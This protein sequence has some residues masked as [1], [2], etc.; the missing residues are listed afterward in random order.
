MVLSMTQPFKHPKTGI[1][2]YRKV[3]PEPL[4]A[5][6][7]KREEK[8]SLKTKDPQIAKQRHIE[9][10][11][12]I[13]RHWAALSEPATN[14]SNKQIVA[15]SGILYRDATE[16]FAE[17]PGSPETWEHLKRVDK[18]AREKGK[19][20]QWYGQTVDELLAKEGLNVD[21]PS[22][23]QLLRAASDAIL[24]A[25]GQLQRNAGGDYRPDPDAERFPE[26]KA[27]DSNQGAALSKRKQSRE[28][29]T[30]EELLERWWKEAQAAGLSPKTYQSYSSVIIR[31]VKFLKHNDPRRVT[32]EDI[33]AYKDARLSEVNSRTGKAISAKTVKDSD[34][35]GLKT[36]FGWAKV[37]LLVPSNPAEGITLKVG[38]RVSVRPKG[39]TDEE[40]KRLLTACD[41]VQRGT[42]GEK[43]YLAKRWIPWICAYTGSRVGEVAQLRKQDVRKIGETWVI[44]LT[45]EAGTIKTKTARQVVVHE[46][47]LERGFAELIDNAAD[48]YLFVS[49]KGKRVNQDNPLGSI[50]AVT[51]RVRDFAREVVPDPQ[52]QPNHGWRHRFKTIWMDQ[53]LNPRI[54]DAIQGHSSGRVSDDYGDVTIK[55]QKRAMDK[56]PRQV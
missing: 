34:L 27:E 13:E 32:P 24:Q 11:L 8:R 19:L 1:Y 29:V 5:A 23:E 16:R 35:A 4:R 51:N 47:L 2:Y 26:W 48:G 15:L 46:H 49:V 28:K 44:N 55:A 36:I 38:K 9:V 3:V 17:E 31:L 39:F 43:M 53:G 41:H 50:K 6:I 54:C 37:N 14:L 30:I 7:G 56:I 33:V 18:Q 20:D 12:E 40:A 45:P 10:S 42:M 22:R 21:G 25:I 52:V